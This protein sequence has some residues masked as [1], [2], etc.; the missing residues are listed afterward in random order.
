LKVFAGVLNATFRR[1]DPHGRLGGEE[2][3][4]VLSN[5]TDEEAVAAAERVR[6]ALAG[7]NIP[8]RDAAAA[9]QTMSCT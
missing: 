3:A 1:T 4:A 6:L 2:F 9:H 7:C 5:V 8:D